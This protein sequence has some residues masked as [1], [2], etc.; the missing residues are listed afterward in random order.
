[1]NQ[2]KPHPTPLSAATTVAKKL[3]DA[4]YE[5]YI[6]GSFCVNKILGRPHHGDIDMTTSASPQEMRDILNVVGEIGEKYGT[7]I[8]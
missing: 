7:L 8:I 1:M 2:G 5:A 6:I 3:Q 4:G